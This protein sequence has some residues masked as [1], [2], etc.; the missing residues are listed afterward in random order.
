[1][2]ISV[3]PAEDRIGATRL[4][5]LYGEY[6]ADIRPTVT[7][8]TLQNYRAQIEPARLFWVQYGKTH[9]WSITRRTGVDLVH[10][11]RTEY[12]TPKG[13]A[14]SQN[15]LRTVV[16]RVRQY[17]RWIH[18]SGRLAIDISQWVDM[19]SAQK[20]PVKIL[21]SAEIIA[22]FDACVGMSAVRDMALL[23]FLIE[24][25][26][27]RIEA[28]H[29]DY[30]NVQWQQANGYAFL[31]VV[32]GF[33]DHDKRRTVVFGPKTVKMLQIMRVVYKR[34]LLEGSVFDLTNSGVRHVVA[35]VSRR[36][37]VE[38]AAHDLRKTF[39]T[40]WMNNCT[41]PSPDLAKQLLQLQLGH[42]AHDVAERHYIQLTHADVAKYFVS[43]L[44]G[45][46]LYGL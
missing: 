35:G 20:S 39:A 28:A 45:I 7:T 43:P 25:G 30:K 40:H 19:P 42:S 15:T 38:F 11:L 16:R 36:S 22:L 14:I 10:W 29:L 21:T 27:R 18:T 8:K 2:N 32:K 31:E 34:N 5:E 17:L 33:R 1:M 9:E 37:G 12:R 6:I 26:A 23:C 4:L 46:E 44:D 13:N 24:T 3:I 41:T